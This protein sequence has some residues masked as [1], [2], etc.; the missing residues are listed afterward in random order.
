MGWGEWHNYQ[1]VSNW[2]ITVLGNIP[3][4]F[5][6]GSRSSMQALRSARAAGALTAGTAAALLRL[7]LFLQLAAAAALA[8]AVPSHLLRSGQASLLL[9]YRQAAFQASGPP[10]CFAHLS[11]VQQHTHAAGT[12]D[13]NLLLPAGT[14]A[15]AQRCTLIVLQKTATRLLHSLKQLVGGQI[16]KE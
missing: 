2:E 11:A 9:L 5:R 6:S 14:A 12:C 4:S 13:E 15:Q 10:S 1:T 7:L 3:R 16:P 8:A